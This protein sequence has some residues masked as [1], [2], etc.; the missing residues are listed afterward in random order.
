MTSED[1]TEQLQR[2]QPSM[3]DVTES[4]ALD[5]RVDLDDQPFA[6]E[7]ERYQ[8]LR[9]LAKGGMGEILLAKDTRIAR[10]VAVKVLKEGLRVKRDYRSRFLLEARLQGQLEHPAIVPVHDLGE[11]ET[12]ELYFTMKCVR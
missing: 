6:P 7:V 5:D 12:G 4:G 9:S 1:K 3:A 10:Q 8:F 11:R 2:E